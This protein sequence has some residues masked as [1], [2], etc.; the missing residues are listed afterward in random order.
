MEPADENDV[1]VFVGRFNVGAVSLHL[2]MIYAKSKAESRDFMRFWISS[3]ND[4]KSS[5]PYV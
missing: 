5:Y 3:G 4:P 1:P 2:P